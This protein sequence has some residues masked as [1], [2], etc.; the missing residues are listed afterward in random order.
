MRLTK[1]IK[2]ENGN[3]RV[4]CALYDTPDCQIHKVAHC[5]QCPAM[6]G[7]LNQ[8]NIFENAYYGKEEQQ[9]EDVEP[10]C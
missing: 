5:G 6:A 7:I 3:E 1:I 10:G 2:D 9:N 8:L 4:C